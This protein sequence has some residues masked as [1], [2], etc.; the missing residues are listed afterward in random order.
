MG[1]LNWKMKVIGKIMNHYVILSPK[2]L[3]KEFLGKSKNYLET[4][5]NCQLNT[6]CSY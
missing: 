4:V 6:K 2:I 1:I 5:K 3:F